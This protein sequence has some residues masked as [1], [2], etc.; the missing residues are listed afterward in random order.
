MRRLALGFAFAVT[1]TLFLATAVNAVAPIKVMLVDG[2]N[3]HRN[4]VDQ[5]PVLKKVLEDSGLFQ[6]TV[7]SVKPEDTTT[8]KAD[9]SQY[10]VVV[11]NYNTGISGTPPSWPEDTRK[12]FQNYISN[13]GGLVSL[14]ATDNAFPDWK[15]FNEMIG[16][17][18]W[19][20]RNEKCG[21]YVYYKDGKIVRDN[22]P[23]R[24]GSHDH[25][26]YQVTVRD[27]E[28]PITKGLPKVWLHNNDELYHSLRGP[29]TNMTVL[30][31]A[32]SATT[33]R[34]EPILMAITYGKGR[35]FHNVQGHDVVGMSSVD[36]VTTLLRGT[37]WAATGK[38]TQK[39]PADF[40]TNSEILA[41]RMDLAKMDPNYGQPAAGRGAAPGPAGRVGVPGGPAA[42]T[43][44][45]GAAITAAGAP[46][47]RGAGGGG[48]GQAGAS[49]GG[50]TWGS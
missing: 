45:G 26:F 1:L 17:G 31:T 46:G 34:D 33:K 32:Y 13:G 12:A 8:F 10:Q 20:A 27:S 15:E 9:W 2:N 49:A 11:M 41:Y 25:D 16:L 28:H 39:A 6:V 30:A 14:H 3:N 22:S 37:E 5:T 50:C 36:F 7:V 35:V 42:P 21:P 24:G 43:A 29:A 38:V 18:G 40:P 48:G 19:G 4:W 23:G 47:P 44:A